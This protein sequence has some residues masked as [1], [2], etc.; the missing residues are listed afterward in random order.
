MSGP[1][2]PVI[3]RERVIRC[4]YPAIRDRGPPDDG[5]AGGR[6]ADGMCRA[7][8]RSGD[9][10]RRSPGGVGAALV[11][12]SATAYLLHRVGRR[13]GATTAEVRDRL[14]GDDVVRHP[15][16]QSTRA[17]TV[18]APPTA[19][20]PWIA[21]MGFPSHRAGWY[22][23]RW[24]DRVTF[25]IRAAS[26]DEIRPE[27]QAIE[28]GDRIPDSDDWSVWFTVAEVDPP[29]ALVLHS[30]RHVLPPVRTVDFSWAFVVRDAGAGRSRVLIRARSAYTPA[31]AR[32]FVELVIGPADYVNAGAMLRGIRARVERAAPATA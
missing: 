6:H 22:T 1:P 9:H 19:V 25:G 12:V 31:S 13:S 2:P 27:L 11:A 20:W 8:R 16:W 5:R 28:V 7:R 26:A 23:P 18:A 30:T 29:R 15:A 10:P 32:W 17:I 3:A 4:G 21:Q 14:P 24:L